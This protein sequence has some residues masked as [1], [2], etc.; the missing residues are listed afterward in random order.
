MTIDR[1]IPTIWFLE[2]QKKKTKKISTR[3]FSLGIRKIKIYSIYLNEKLDFFF[4]V[5]WNKRR[6]RKSLSCQSTWRKTVRR[7]I[8][9]EFP[10]YV[11]IHLEL[12]LSIFFDRYLY[13]H[14]ES[15]IINHF[16]SRT[17]AHSFSPSDCD[18]ESIWNKA[19]TTRQR[20]SVTTSSFE[21]CF[22]FVLRDENLSMSFY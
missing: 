8:A 7:E 21:I 9:H 15:Q 13:F 5:E 6:G 1:S 18:H 19:N 2:N 11:E 12:R 3:L 20:C 17:N 14:R 22:D 10:F 16:I 4:V